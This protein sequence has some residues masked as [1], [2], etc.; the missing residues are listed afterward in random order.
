M[1][2]VIAAHDTQF[3]MNDLTKFLGVGSGNLR[4]AD[5]EIME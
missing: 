1:W 5:P 3:N 4:G 2:L